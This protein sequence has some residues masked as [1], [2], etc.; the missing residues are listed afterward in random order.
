MRDSISGQLSKRG[1]LR[2]A[3][4]SVD[5]ATEAKAKT[6]FA[7]YRRRT[8]DGIDDRPSPKLKGG[9]D[10]RRSAI[11]EYADLRHMLSDVDRQ[12]HT[13]CTDPSAFSAQC[14]TQTVAL[15]AAGT[16]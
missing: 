12:S 1:L 9:H 16:S 7:A 10:K 13:P 8:S 15:C 6:L 3:K 2:D 4:E 14:T 11:V 5:E